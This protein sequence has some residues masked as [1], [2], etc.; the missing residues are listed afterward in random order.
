MR[1]GKRRGGRDDRRDRD[2]RRP[3]RGRRDRDRPQTHSR[4][5]RLSRLI[6]FFLRHHPEEAG[7]EMDDRGGVDVDELVEAVRSRPGLET[8]TRADVERLVADQQ[9]QRFQISEGRIRARY[10]HSLQRP[11]R[12]EPAEPPP[13]LF[14][15]TTPEAAETVLAEGI[16]PGQRQ[17]VHLSVDV[18][19]AREVGRRR[20]PEPTILR[21]DTVGCMKA[22][23]RF[24]AASPTVWLSGPIPPECITRVE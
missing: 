8:L 24:Y 17:Y 4:Q 7:L 15:G 21:V 13:D 23:V 22:G 5:E 19:A 2:R 12:Y 20:A 18:P 3:E 11:I 1:N 10:G 16:E 9:S 6:A 14:H